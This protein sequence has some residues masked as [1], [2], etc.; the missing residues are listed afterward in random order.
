MIFSL[1]NNWQLLR[2]TYRQLAFLWLVYIA[3]VTVCALF[4]LSTAR[5]F[6]G[7]S[8]EHAL[9]NLQAKVTFELLESETVLRSA[10]LHVRNMILN[11]EKAADMREYIAEFN[12]Y[13]LAN[14]EHITGAAG[15]YGVFNVYGGAFIN[16][17]GEV[18]LAR[19]HTQL[20][21]LW[22]KAAI[23]AKG[24][25]AVTSP[26]RD[27]M[28]DEWKITFSRH[29]ADEN[30]RT[31]AVIGLDMSL[32]PIRRYFSA[33]RLAEGGNGVLVDQDLNIIAATLNDLIGEPLS[34]LKA[35]DIFKI[36]GELNRGV[37][38][39]GYKTV[40]NRRN[41]E[42][43]VVYSRK[44]ENGW[45]V[46]IMTP[47]NNF[48]KDIYDT[49]TVIVISGMLLQLILSFIVLRIASARQRSEEK[50]KQ[51]SNFLA[52][53]SHEIRTPMNAIIGFAELA[54]RENIPPAAY[55]H[56]FNIKQAGANLLSII[57]DILDFSKIES[58]KLELV[59]G[60]YLFSSLVNDVVSIIKMR[61]TYSRLRFIVNIDSNIPNALHG[62][63]IRVRQVLLNLLSN[64]V[65]YTDRGFVSLTIS[66]VV[67]DGGTVTLDVE[68]ADSG[69]GIKREDIDKL[70]KDFVQVDKAKN[71]G[72]EGTGLGL[73]ITQNILKAMG[74]SIRVESEYGKGSVFTATLPQKFNDPEKHAFVENRAN[75]KVLLY[76]RREIYVDS[77][78]RTFENLGVGYELAINDAEFGEKIK[79]ADYRFVFTAP[80]LGEV[81]KNAL[82]EHKSNA[83]M[84]L[85][86][87]FGDKINDLNA[88]MLPMPAYSITMAN[89]LNGASGGLDYGARKENFARFIAP[90]AKVLIVDDTN[91]NLRV[92]E[93]LL[94]PYKMQ[95]TLCRSGFQAI[96]AVKSE[97]FDLVFMD[98]M[99]PGMDGIEATQRIRS[100]GDEYRKLPIIALTANAVTGAREMFLNEG[101]SDF[102][103]K[104]IE[105]AKLNAVLDKWLPQDK[106]RSPWEETIRFEV[107]TGKDESEEGINI[108]IDGVDVGKGI[109]LSGG[110][111]ANYLRTITM[112]YED[113]FEKTEEI[114]RCLSME[115]LQ[116]YTTHVHGLKSA[117]ASIG[118]T[119]L[120]ETARELEDAGKKGDMAYINSY[121]PKLLMELE[122]LL[123]NIGRFVNDMKAGKGGG[124]A[125][126]ETLAAELVRL[127]SALDNFDSEMIDQVTLVLQ[128]YEDAADLGGEV[129][130]ILQDVLIGEYEEAVSLIDKLLER[131]GWN[132]IAQPDNL[133]I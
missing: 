99:M 40:N 83:R 17:K 53:M 106:R 57:N 28:T 5:D 74:G 31:L 56:I 125:N 97:R 11:G 117:S 51:K 43:V 121:T 4:V 34:A 33:T 98:H 69:R 114:K 130:A 41:G 60:D 95:V 79:A 70:F 62:D 75:K 122:S 54:M 44:I 27:E 110:N 8:A 47:L 119:V 108:V 109:I 46:G 72:I 84:V 25:I 120:S 14:S 32:G 49:G 111:V 116:L 37:S 20:G 3:L 132:N 88:A 26:H 94:S 29:L 24:G 64:A 127:R 100:L 77:I 45:H 38:L 123:R 59:E 112:F 63:E 55:E 131:L 66:G 85:L 113:G 10:S 30:G 21:N 16:R 13:V 67:N 91:T 89:I 42:A 6:L 22:Y 128:G 133:Y 101:C 65:K 73:T 103:S 18:A 78:I 92:A 81:V 52:N 9:S 61:A 7:K 90:D 2:R 1:K 76:E 80:I 107:W 129:K 93:G 118:A 58:G 82:L 126:V 87:E 48:Y 39:S 86:A 105:V 15:I 12:D 23:D 115:D 124:E 96:E 102:V 68:V 36:M 19:N 50:S 35:P 104:P 71:K